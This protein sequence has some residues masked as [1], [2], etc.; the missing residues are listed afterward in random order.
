MGRVQLTPTLGL[1]DVPYVIP[2][3]RMQ[4]SRL[5]FFCDVANVPT[6]SAFTPVL[7]Y[8]KNLVPHVES[9]IVSSEESL[10]GLVQR[11]STMGLSD[12]VESWLEVLS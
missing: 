1:A 5:E 6:N 4:Q 2:A 12:S 7:Q 11:L 3:L 8:V 10:R 9:L